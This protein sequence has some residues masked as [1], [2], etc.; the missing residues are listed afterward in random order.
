MQIWRFKAFVLAQ[1]FA[2]CSSSERYVC[3]THTFLL[4]NEQCLL[5]TLYRRSENN[6]AKELHS[7][8]HKQEN[9]KDKKERNG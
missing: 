9:I 3:I 6:P 2:L 5:K 7:V 1:A 8:T 4:D